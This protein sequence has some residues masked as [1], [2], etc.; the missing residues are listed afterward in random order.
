MEAQCAANKEQLAKFGIVPIPDGHAHRD[1]PFNCH[2]KFTLAIG[3]LTRI[4]E[5]R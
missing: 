3:P 4:V 2:L 1:R 5:L